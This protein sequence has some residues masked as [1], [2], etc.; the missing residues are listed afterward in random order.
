MYWNC[1][2]TKVQRIQFASVTVASVE[3]VRSSDFNED[4]CFA[5]RCA[6]A[7]LFI[8]VPVSTCRL[9]VPGLAER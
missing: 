9:Q 8:L 1:P 6:S 4:D 2:V 5:R 7:C 3:V